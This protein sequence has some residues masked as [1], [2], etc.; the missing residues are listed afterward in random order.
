L[1]DPGITTKH[2]FDLFTL[3]ENKLGN[4]E[5]RKDLSMAVQAQTI[6]FAGRK[7]K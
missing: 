7:G 2:P 1:C 3:L 4:G 6:S 5:K